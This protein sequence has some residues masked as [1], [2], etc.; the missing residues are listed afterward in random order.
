LSDKSGTEDN[1]SDDRS[2]DLNNLNDDKED[3][4]SESS[5]SEDSSNSDSD[6]DDDKDRYYFKPI[7]SVSITKKNKPKQM[8]SFADDY[9]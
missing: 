2:N 7:H 6:S 3:E 8:V 9:W 1:L 4:S 5:E